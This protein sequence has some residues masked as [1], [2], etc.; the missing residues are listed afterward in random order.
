MPHEYYICSHETC[1][2]R[3]TCFLWDDPRLEWYCRFHRGKKGNIQCQVEECTRMT[4][5]YK[6]VQMNYCWAHRARHITKKCMMPKCKKYAILE[7]DRETLTLFCLQHQFSPYSI[8]QKGKRSEL[9]KCNFILLR[10]KESGRKCLR[11]VF[12]G[13]DYCKRHINGQCKFILVAGKNKGT[14]CLWGAIN[15]EGYCKRHFLSQIKPDLLLAT[16]HYISPRPTEL[17]FEEKYFIS[18]RMALYQIPPTVARVSQ[19]LIKKKYSNVTIQI[20]S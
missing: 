13:N 18:N 11:G 9:R 20:I 2:V 10:G 3:T 19:V 1:S 15:L 12:D 17:S 5:L 16:K 4:D 6:G 14:R 8:K 7:S